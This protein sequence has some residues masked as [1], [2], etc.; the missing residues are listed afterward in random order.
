MSDAIPLEPPQASSGASGVRFLLASGRRAEAELA[1]EQIVALMREG[2]R[3]RISPSSCGK[4]T[5]GGSS[6]AGLRFVRYPPSDRRSAHPE[7]DG[8]R[9]RVPERSA[10]R[11][12]EDADGMLSYLRSPYSGSPRKPRA[13][14]NSDT[15]AAPPK[16]RGPCRARPKHEHGLGR[17][18]VGYRRRGPGIVAARVD[19]AA[20]SALA[21]HMLVAGLR[22]PFWAT[23][24]S[25]TTRVHTLLCEGHWRRW[26]GLAPPTRERSS[27]P[28]P[29]SSCRR[30]GP[31]WRV[32]FECS[33]FKGPE[34]GGSRWS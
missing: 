15:G 24:T 17:A 18:A 3:P 30:D 20:A 26:R 13:I 6:R 7:G 27:V 19:A 9:A 29:R 11:V 28:F 12:L 22:A 21:R 25:T 31:T 14:W 1:A 10:G 23:A 32:A 4:C 33:A 34:Q 8:H 16:A 2:R 5:H